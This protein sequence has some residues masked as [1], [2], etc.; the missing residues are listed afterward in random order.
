MASAAFPL[1]YFGPVLY[2]AALAQHEEV[3]F[4]AWEHYPK[5]SFRNRCV[6]YGANGPLALSIPTERPRERVPV[7]RMRIAYGEDWQQL[8]WR[9]LETAYRSSPYFEFYEDDLA[10][11]FSEQ[12]VNLQAFTEATHRTV[13]RLLGWE[14]PFHYTDRY[15]EASGPDPRTSFPAKKTHPG[16]ADLPEY[17]QVFSPKFGF[18]PNLSILDL[19][20]NEGPQASAY[21]RGIPAL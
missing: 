8:H 1:F 3:A 18:Q 6:I 4:E 12:P 2:Y 10:P 15:A 11:L 14:Q 16:A 20:C 13:L 7:N 17:A 5:Q 19:L 21:L 9:S